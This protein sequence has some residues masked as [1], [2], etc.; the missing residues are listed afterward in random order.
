MSDLRQT[1]LHLSCSLQS[2][3]LPMQP[4]SSHGRLNLLTR[5]LRIDTSSFPFYTCKQASHTCKMI[6]T[7]NIGV[8]YYTMQRRSQI[9]NKHAKRHTGSWIQRISKTTKL[10]PAKVSNTVESSGYQKQQSWIQR[11]FQTQLNPADIKNN[12]VEYSETFKQQSKPRFMHSPEDHWSNSCDDRHTHTHTHEHTQTHKHRHTHT[13]THTH[14]GSLWWQSFKTGIAS[15][16][17][18]AMFDDNLLR[19]ASLQ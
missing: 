11:K 19:Q 2:T 9:N 8:Y 10:N 7:S 3:A 4:R 13:H 18:W 5:K 16:E 1:V 14:W 6:V 12:K 15:V 17:L